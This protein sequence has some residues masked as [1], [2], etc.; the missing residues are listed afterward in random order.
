MRKASASTKNASAAS[1]FMFVRVQKNPIKI[2]TIQ[3]TSLTKIQSIQEFKQIKDASF[4]FIIVSNDVTSTLHQSKCN[5]L[6]DEGFSEQTH[7]W[8]STLNLAEKSFA[9]VMCDSCKPE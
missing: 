7:H 5:T 8:F 4:G 9:V 1:T 3:K 6:T 2:L